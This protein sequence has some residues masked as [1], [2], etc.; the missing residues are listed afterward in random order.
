MDPQV[1][2]QQA[3]RPKMRAA[4]KA[5]RYD[6]RKTREKSASADL[7]TFSYT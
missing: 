7:F 4:L 1:R 5:R 6:Y 2:R 3:P